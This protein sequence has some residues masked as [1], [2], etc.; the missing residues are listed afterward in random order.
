MLFVR[1]SLCSI[2]NTFYSQHVLREIIGPA[3]LFVRLRP[4]GVGVCVRMCVR[5]LDLHVC[6]CVCVWGGLIIACMC[7]WWGYRMH[8][9]ASVCVWGG[10]VVAW[11]IRCALAYYSM[12]VFVVGLSHAWVSSCL[13][14][15]PVRVGTPATHTC[16]YTFTYAYAHTHAHTHAHMHT[17]TRTH[18]RMYTHA[19]VRVCMHV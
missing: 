3:V 7:V 9:C 15:S 13:P 10:V 16:T 6:A 8:V 12:H 2:E 18:T 4:R 19:Y 5:V 17:C 1:L 14:S 11:R